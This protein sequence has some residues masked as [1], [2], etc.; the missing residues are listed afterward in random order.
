MLPQRV[1]GVLW[2]EA[3]PA[4]IVLQILLAVLEILDSLSSMVWKAYSIPGGSRHEKV[5]FSD[6]ASA[7]DHMDVIVGDVGYLP[8]R[9]QG[10][11]GMLFCVLR[12]AGRI[13]QMSRLRTRL[14]RSRRRS[15]LGA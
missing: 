6:F 15:Q 7:G 11:L 8:N 14:C 3:G 9:S 12:P 13:S 1:V 10:R 2:G 4:A 5:V